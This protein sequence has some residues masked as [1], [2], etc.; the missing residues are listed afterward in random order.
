MPQAQSAPDTA[1]LTDFSLA[2][3]SK[4]DIEAIIQKAGEAKVDLVVKELETA[5]RDYLAKVE[6]MERLLAPY[7]LTLDAYLKFSNNPATLRRHL[8]DAIFDGGNRKAPSSNRAVGYNV[9]VKY[10]SKTDPKLT[11]SG[12][13]KR[14]R[15]LKEHLERGGTLDDVLVGAADN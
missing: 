13:G 12:R 3:A 15:W 14:P 9:P 4:E 1:S 8:F 5:R 2:G 7:R 6:S 11:W 10:R